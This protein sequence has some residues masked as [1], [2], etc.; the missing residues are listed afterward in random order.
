MTAQNTP[1]NEPTNSSAKPK[2]RGTWTAEPRARDE[3][4]SPSPHPASSWLV[5]VGIAAALVAAIWLAIAA[6]T[7]GY[8]SASSARADQTYSASPQELDNRE[9]QRFHN[10]AEADRRQVENL[11]DEQQRTDPSDDR[12]LQR[13]HNRAEA[14]RRQVENLRL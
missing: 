6:V 7:D 4:R 1:T 9:L 2:S 8:G 13:F 11:R 5:S 14:D 12:E 3:Q 10:R